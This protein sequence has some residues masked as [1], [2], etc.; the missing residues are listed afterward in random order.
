MTL[1]IDAFFILLSICAILLCATTIGII[2]LLIRN[3]KQEH[4][5]EFS[6]LQKH[7]NFLTQNLD[8]KFSQT[9]SMLNK[10]LSE[11]L[12]SSSHIANTS[13]KNIESLTKKLTELGETNREI[14][15]IWDRLEG[16]E[17]IL[18]NPKQRGNLG[19]Y[20]LTELLENVFTPEQ[21]ATQYQLKNGIVDAAL[22]I[23]DRTIPIDAKFPQENYQKLIS[24][25]DEFSQKKYA[26][27]LKKDIQQRIDETSKY[28]L[29][30][31]NTTDFAFM[32]IPAEW[33][34]YDIFIGNIWGIS[35][36]ELI[37]YGFS[38]HVIIA[39]P[40]SF[41][42]YL[43]TVLQWMKSLQIEQQAK[44][45]QKYVLKL[46]KDMLQYEEVF[47]KIGNSLWTTVNHYN[48]AQKRLQIIDS[49]IVKIAPD[50]EKIIPQREILD[51]PN[52]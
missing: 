42:A 50:G 2:V 17:H 15:E 38:K 49:D 32:L 19:E 30:E 44:E 45:I 20:F 7:L 43:Q 29:P 14:K 52:S 3:K 31:E 22:F 18:K 12:K 16:L 25:E 34:Y 10:N 6:L 36:R 21:Y 11:S 27:A 24:S 39:S 28:I 48:A 8:T 5:W 40:S 35:S 47:S 13:N 37:T 33:L 41:Y 4:T 9:H 23:W 26:Q 1:T 46:Q 51:S